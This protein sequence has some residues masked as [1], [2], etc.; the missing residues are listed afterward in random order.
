MN[1]A[2]DRQNH[3]ATDSKPLPAAARKP[4]M[5]AGIGFVLLLGAGLIVAQITNYSG[6]PIRWIYNDVDAALKQ[7]AESRRRVFLRLHEADCPISAEHDQDLFSR[8]FA[9]I[10]LD[11]MVACR[12]EVGPTDPVRG[13]FGFDGAPLMLVLDSDGKQIRAPLRGE[14]GK[15]QFQ[16]Q[17]RIHSE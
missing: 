17:T 4:S 3:P 8:R 15:L 9:R 5:K 6:P 12:V 14:V 1:D 13:R 2:T 16:T 7:A 11:K 10:R